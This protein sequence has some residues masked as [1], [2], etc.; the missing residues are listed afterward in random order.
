MVSV[1]LI[2]GLVALLV[3]AISALMLIRPIGQIIRIRRVPTTPVGLLPDAG[4]AEVFGRAAGGTR[5]SPLAQAPCLF[6]Q[7]EVQEYRSNG[8]SGHWATIFRQASTEPF[9][10]DDGT[11]G[12]EVF[13]EGASLT[14]VDDVRASRGLFGNMS[15]EMLAAIERLGVSPTG[16]LGFGRRL[17]VFERRLEPGE[18]VY[19]LGYVERIA[20]RPVLRSV[21][22]APLLL[23][24]RSEKD[25]LAALYARVGLTALVPIL[26]IV[27]GLT[28]LIAARVGP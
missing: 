20:G 9:A 26:M 11:G 7:V 4:P 10:I 25:V 23:A 1:L 16:F 8:K 2:A 21:P 17:R 13:P 5:A 27:I 18:Q 19:A 22:D 14:L 28:V 3:L 6:W 12:V 24:D 15:D